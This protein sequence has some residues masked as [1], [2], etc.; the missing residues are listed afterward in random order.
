MRMAV[1]RV[2]SIPLNSPNATVSGWPTATL[3]LAFRSITLVISQRQ[4]GR[5]M[6]ERGVAL[7]R[8]GFLTMGLFDGQDPGPAHQNTLEMIELAERQ[9]GVQRRGADMATK[10]GPALGWRPRR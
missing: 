2:R 7:E 6:P 10:L 5:H 1:G 4:R 9:P 8:L 3:A